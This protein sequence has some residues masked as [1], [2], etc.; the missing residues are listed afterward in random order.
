M[1]TRE[2][3]AIGTYVTRKSSKDLAVMLDQVILSGASIDVSIVHDQEGEDHVITVTAIELPIRREGWT[4]YEC[5]ITGASV[6]S[7]VITLQNDDTKPG[8]I[9]VPGHLS[10]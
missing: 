1:M 4:S 8:T 3:L 9:V 7:G 5:T 2:R 6:V 10:Q